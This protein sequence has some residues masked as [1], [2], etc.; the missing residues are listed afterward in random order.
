MS[1]AT[2]P[3]PVIILLYYFGDCSLSPFWL[4]FI[5]DPRGEISLSSCLGSDI[6]HCE[7]DHGKQLPREEDEER[8]ANKHED[9]GEH[10]G[11]QSCEY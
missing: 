2:L 1:I 10:K 5:A 3:Y 9:S 6:D 7:R 8:V 4:F 11:R